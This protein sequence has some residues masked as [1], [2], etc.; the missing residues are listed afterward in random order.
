M[1]ILLTPFMINKNKKSNRNRWYRFGLT[2]I[3]L[4]ETISFS[5]QTPKRST[6]SNGVPHSQKIICPNIVTESFFVFK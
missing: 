6:Y 4:S 5:L 1:I 3:G 2:M